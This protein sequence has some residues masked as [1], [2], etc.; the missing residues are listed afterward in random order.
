MIVCEHCKNDDESLIEKV[1]EQTKMIVYVC[2]VCSKMFSINKS[3]N[4]NENGKEGR[5]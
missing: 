5:R 1:Y 2:G 3:I 4:L